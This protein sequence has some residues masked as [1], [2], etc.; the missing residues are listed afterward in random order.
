MFILVKAEIISMNIL[1]TRIVPGEG[2]D[3]LKRHASVKINSRNQ[4]MSREELL[5]EIKGV[6]AVLSMLNDRIDREAMDAAGS[7]LKVISN[8][9]VG[10]DNVELEEATKRG[11]IVANT[12]FVLNE[13]VADM[14]FALLLA[15]GRRIVEADNYV[16]RGE[17]KHWGQAACSAGMFTA[18][19]WASL[20]WAA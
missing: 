11:I 10:Y 18:R 20:A 13:A 16:R 2:I 1:V 14:A 19:R 12:P 15:L 6:H 4:A 5:Q 8:Y 3:I 9:A 7:N 17:W